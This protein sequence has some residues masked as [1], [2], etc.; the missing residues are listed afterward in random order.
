MKLEPL[1]SPEKRTLSFYTNKRRILGGRKYLHW[2]PIH[3]IPWFRDYST[4]RKQQIL[5]A[6]CITLE[7]SI[8]QAFP[9]R[10][11]W[12]NE[13]YFRSS[14]TRYS[15]VFWNDELNTQFWKQSNFGRNGR[16]ELKYLEWEERLNMIWKFYFGFLIMPIANAGLFGFYRTFRLRISTGFQILIVCS[17]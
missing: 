11:I 4:L 17:N 7:I 3:S 14:L 10:H 9:F 6:G 2:P 8:L 5:H 13:Y 12:E 1:S 15:L 16:I